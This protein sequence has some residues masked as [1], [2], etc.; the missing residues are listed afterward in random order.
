MFKK[1]Q[2]G[3]EASRP[4]R[5]IQDVL[6]LDRGELQAHR[7]HVPNRASAG[8]FHLVL[9]NADTCSIIFE[10]VRNAAES[11]GASVSDRAAAPGGEIQQY[12][13]PDGV[14]V[15]DHRLRRASIR[16]R[17]AHLRVLSTPRNRGDGGWG[18][19]IFLSIIE[20]IMAAFGLHPASIIWRDESERGPVAVVR[21]SQ[22]RACNGPLLRVRRSEARALIDA[23]VASPKAAMMASMIDRRWEQQPSWFVE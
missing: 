18:C 20:S 10:L 9:G 17:G 15:I 1:G 14:L 19:S 7:D 8:R 12:H 16:R 2:R 21:P 11:H 4:Q 3:K 6:A 5:L 22:Q 13:G 23:G